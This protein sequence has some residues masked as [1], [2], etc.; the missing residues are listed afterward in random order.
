ML[1]VARQLFFAEG[2]E[3]TS[4]PQIIDGVGIAMGTLDHCITR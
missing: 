1:D 3:P 2:Y 4:I